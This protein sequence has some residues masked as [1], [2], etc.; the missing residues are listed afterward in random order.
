MTKPVAMLRVFDITHEDGTLRVHD[1]HAIRGCE[2]LPIGD[3]KL[4]VGPQWIEGA[5]PKGVELAWLRVQFQGG[6][7]EGGWDWM[8]KVMLGT[9]VDLS[10]PEDPT[11]HPEWCE[12]GDWKGESYGESIYEDPAVITHWMPYVIPDAG[13]F[14]LKDMG[15]TE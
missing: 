5:P 4:Y 1:A 2:D 14:G 12:A 11:H 15:P 9:L 10:D 7:G 6:D 8:V 13:N 3:H